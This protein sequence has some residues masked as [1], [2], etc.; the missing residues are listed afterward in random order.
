M[1]TS[2]RIA[3]WN[4]AGAHKIQS[5]ERFDYSGE[6]IAYFVDCLK[7]IN[8]D[9][10]CVQESHTNEQRSN[11]ADIAKLLGMPYVYNV[12]VSPSHID[13]E[14]Q[15]GNAILS[16]VALSHVADVQ[17]PY[18]S[19]DLFFS[20]GRPAAV[21]HK[22]IQIYK[23]GDMVIANTQ[24]MPLGIFG[25]SYASGPGAELASSIQQLLIDNLSAP[26]L[27]CGDLNFDTPQDI[28]PELYNTLRLHETLPD[29]PTRPAKDMAKHTPDHILVSDGIAVAAADVIEVEADHYLCYADITLK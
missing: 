5:L 7:Q 13:S 15:L 24:M 3:S 2:L 10:V 17:Y 27:L 22:M 8:P 28:Y 19:F 20:D 6:D 11:A 4:I 12:A 16:K 23:L 14:F 29:V 1:N 26:L 25:A 18:P 9:I 21:H